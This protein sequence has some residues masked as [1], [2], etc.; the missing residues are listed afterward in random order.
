MV[1][2]T[3]VLE[4]DYDDDD[5]MMTSEKQDCPPNGCKLSSPGYP[6]LPPQVVVIICTLIVIIT[7]FVINIIS[8]LNSNPHLSSTHCADTRSLPPAATRR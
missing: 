3:L 6:G 8:I 7:V 1:I 2:M 4:D 5:I